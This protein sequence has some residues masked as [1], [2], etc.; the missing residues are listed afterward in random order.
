MRHREW[1]RTTH[2]VKGRTWPVEG[3]VI[4][5]KVMGLLAG[6]VI[7]VWISMTQMERRY[8]APS[9]ETTVADPQTLKPTAVPEPAVIQV[10]S[11]MNVSDA[12]DSPHL[13]PQPQAGGNR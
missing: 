1:K 12:A 4:G 2:D 6:Y 13:Q 10:G 7:F 3:I 8:L 9:R 5:L 11:P